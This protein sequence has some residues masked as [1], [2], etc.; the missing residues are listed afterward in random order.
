MPHLERHVLD[1]LPVTVYAVDLSGRITY[2][3]RA[4]ARLA[5]Q[6][7]APQ[8]GDQRALVGASIWDVI[9]DQTAQAQ[10]REAMATL[11]EG[12]ASS[13]SWEFHSA[14]PTEERVFV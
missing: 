12:R 7:G 2:L 5:Q 1:A 8:L 10:I 3:N 13:L 9:G 11:S 4:W 6:N 14:S